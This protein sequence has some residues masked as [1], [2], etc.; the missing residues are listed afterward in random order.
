MR[1]Y[2]RQEHAQAAALGKHAAQCENMAQQQHELAVAEVQ[3]R[4]QLGRAKQESESVARQM[5]AHREAELSELRGHLRWALADAGPSPHGQQIARV[6]HI[7]HPGTTGPRACPPPS[8][9]ESRCTPSRACT[10]RGV[11]CAAVE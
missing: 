2:A 3:Q 4:R 5:L 10:L 9:R 6:A 11:S 1:N 8:S 7:A